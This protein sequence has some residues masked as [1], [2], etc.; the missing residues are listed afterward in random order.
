MKKNWGDNRMKNS[1][2]KCGETPFGVGLWKI[3]RE[4]SFM[5][6]L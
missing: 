1:T 4:S 5:T 2:V 3:L 6:V